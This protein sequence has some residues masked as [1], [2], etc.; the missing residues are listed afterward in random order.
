M[1]SIIIITGVVQVDHEI[2]VFSGGS[3]CRN[4]C[5]ICGIWVMICSRMRCFESPVVRI[6][7]CELVCA[8]CGGFGKLISSEPHRSICFFEWAA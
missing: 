7:M 8:S 1:S 6:A 2:G 4:S 3:S 5:I